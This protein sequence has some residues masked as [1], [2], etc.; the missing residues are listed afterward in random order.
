M[1]LVKEKPNESTATVP[2][3]LFFQVFLGFKKP[4]GSVSMFVEGVANGCDI[5]HKL[6]LIFNRLPRE[7]YEKMSD[8][9][10]SGQ[11]AF[12]Q[13]YLALEDASHAVARASL[14]AHTSGCVCFLKQ[15]GFFF[16]KE[17]KK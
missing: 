5:Y 9:A 14:F 1:V 2:E 4:D 12:M 3:K 15:Q 6:A 10:D 16:I 13:E 7:I 11:D 8:L 17:T